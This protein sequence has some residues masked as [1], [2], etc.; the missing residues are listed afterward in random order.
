[1]NRLG[2]GEEFG[3][4]ESTKPCQ[5]TL[6]SN[7]YQ[8]VQDILPKISIGIAEVMIK[9]AVL[10]FDLHAFEGKDHSFAKGRRKLMANLRANQDLDSAKDL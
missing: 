2:E 9:A 5:A 8:T 3:K 1:V 6:V 4:R 10:H 7:R